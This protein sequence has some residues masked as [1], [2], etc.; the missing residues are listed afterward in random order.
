M[1]RAS[2]NAG[3]LE[4]YV[5]PIASDVSIDRFS[6]DHAEAVI[7]ALPA[8]RRHIAQLIHRSYVPIL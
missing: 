3:R 1:D 6:L 2:H 8:T 4:L 5:Y 7:R